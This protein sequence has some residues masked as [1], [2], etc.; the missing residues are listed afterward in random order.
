MELIQSVF[1]IVR[2]PAF[3]L[4]ATALLTGV[5]VFSFLQGSSAD[6]VTKYKST[7][8]YRSRFANP[9]YRS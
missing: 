3:A 5:G 4:W 9:L 1:D 8:K 2:S 6:K 7:S